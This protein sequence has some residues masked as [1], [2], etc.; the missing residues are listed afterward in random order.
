MLLSR[1]GSVGFWIQTLK[2]RHGWL[3]LLSSQAVLVPSKKQL[4][5]WYTNKGDDTFLGSYVVQKFCSSLDGPL[6][7]A[8]LRNF[9]NYDLTRWPTKSYLLLYTMSLWAWKIYS[10]FWG[11][12]PPPKKKKVTAFFH[13]LS[14]LVCNTFVFICLCSS[15]S[16]PRAIACR[17]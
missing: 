13:Q 9:L 3:R 1:T 15:L 11:P 2:C 6:V 14:V 10:T 4:C 8:C 12:P 16:C 17:N 7:I 5:E